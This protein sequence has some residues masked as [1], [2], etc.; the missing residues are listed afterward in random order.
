M[1]YRE[2]GKQGYRDTQSK[3]TK[4]N[5]RN[6]AVKL[7]RLTRLAELIPFIKAATPQH[8]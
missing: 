7:K 4:G 5:I 8:K 6:A 2:T 3:N 1:D